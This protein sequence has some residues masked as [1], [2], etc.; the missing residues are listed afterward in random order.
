MEYRIKFSGNCLDASIKNL[1]YYRN[2]LSKLVCYSKFYDDFHVVFP[3]GSVR[4]PYQKVNS[5]SGIREISSNGDL[6]IGVRDNG[7]VVYDQRETNNCI[8][9]SELDKWTNIKSVACSDEFVVGLKNDGTVVINT[10]SLNRLKP[11]LRMWGGI[12]YI[13]CSPDLPYGIIN[14]GSAVAVNDL[15][16]WDDI[17]S[18][19]CCYSDGLLGIRKNGTIIKKG[20][21][22]SFDVEK[23]SDIYNAAVN[24]SF[25]VG[26]KNDNSL[27]CTIDEKHGIDLN[28]I[29]GA[30]AIS[31]EPSYRSGNDYMNYIAALYPNGSIKIFQYRTWFNKIIGTGKKHK[32][33]DIKTYRLF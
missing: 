19:H 9:C 2:N 20:D 26:L 7:T 30:V 31:S 8:N 4:S 24:D 27:I 21:H 33:V 12:V 5:W 15:D 23:W 22:I 28:L 25:V 17:K 11:K 32:L 3:D 1:Q 29:K 14:N 13:T 6:I 16:N 18:V 10:N